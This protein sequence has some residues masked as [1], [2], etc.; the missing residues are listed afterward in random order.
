MGIYD[1]AY[2]LAWLTWEGIL[3]FV[4]AILMVLFGMLFQFNFFPQEQ[5]L[6]FVPF[7]PSLSVQHGEDMNIHPSYF[8]ICRVKNLIFFLKKMD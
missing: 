7:V 8:R 6:N 2:W 4:S 5:L 1:L 3:T